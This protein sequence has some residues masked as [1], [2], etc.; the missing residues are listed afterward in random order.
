MIALPGDPSGATTTKCYACP[1]PG[2]RGSIDPRSVYCGP[3]TAFEGFRVLDFSGGIPGPMASMLLGDFGAE[4]LKIESPAGD[5][6]QG[7]PG[8]L[9]WNRNKRRLVLDL[10][11]DHG[12]ATAL[13]LLTTAD[14]A[15]FDQRPGNLERYGLDAGTSLVRNPALVH[16]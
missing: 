8:Y 7:S 14:V 4:V 5:R 1:G 6:A 13:E 16:A 15:L 10:E 9:A 11:A 12:R 3:M 2:A